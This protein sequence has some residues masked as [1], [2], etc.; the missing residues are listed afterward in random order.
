MCS[1]GASG[2][3]DPARGFCVLLP[4][5]TTPVVTHGLTPSRPDPADVCPLGCGA[6]RCPSQIGDLEGRM[7]VEAFCAG[8]VLYIP[9]GGCDTGCFLEGW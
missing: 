1:R 6:L 9:D 4:S 3:G 8:F 7:W 2:C 5:P